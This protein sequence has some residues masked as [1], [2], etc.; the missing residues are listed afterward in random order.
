MDGLEEV[1][2]LIRNIG[3]D[4]EAIPRYTYSANLEKGFP[5]ELTM[6]EARPV[7]DPGTGLL[8]SWETQSEEQL[9]G[10]NILRQRE[11]NGRRVVVNPVWIPA[12]GDQTNPTSYHFIDR[13]AEPG[14]P[15]IY[16][17]DGIT[18][19]GLSSRSRP[20]IAGRADQRR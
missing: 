3:G 11:Q 5:F 4:D 13:S 15:Y 12:V 18:T 20:V 10:F 17:I 2:L 1:L 7:D 6:L 16:S 9:I 14:I 19:S 8:V